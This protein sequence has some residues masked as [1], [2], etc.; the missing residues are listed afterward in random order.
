MSFNSLICDNTNTYDVVVQNFS[1]LAAT[2][3][4]DCRRTI[5]CFANNVSDLAIP[6]NIVNTGA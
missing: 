6:N 3:S 2:R 5:V 4:N 1:N